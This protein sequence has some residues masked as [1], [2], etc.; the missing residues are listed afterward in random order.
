MAEEATKLS[1]TISLMNKVS[2]P[3]LYEIKINKTFQ[4]NNNK[5]LLA[6]G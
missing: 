6:N 1:M 3:A 4:K 5:T 2:V